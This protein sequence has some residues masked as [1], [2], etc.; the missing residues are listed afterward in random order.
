MCSEAVISEITNNSTLNIVLGNLLSLTAVENFSLNLFIS[1][2][3]ILSLL[4]MFMLYSFFDCCL[5][6]VT[7]LKLMSLPWEAL[8][9]IFMLFP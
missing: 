8:T 7:D 4:M 1:L 3:D 6:S 2:L 9:I 5:F